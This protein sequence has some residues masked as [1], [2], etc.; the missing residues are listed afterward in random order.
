MN[1]GMEQSFCGGEAGWLGALKGR[2]SHVGSRTLLVEDHDWEITAAR[3]VWNACFS[4]TETIAMLLPGARHI[5]FRGL[6]R[7][8]FH[9]HIFCS[10]A[11]Y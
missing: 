3:V 5:V 6:C 9:L 4:L 1:L 10:R 11:Q 7:L 2:S 8:R